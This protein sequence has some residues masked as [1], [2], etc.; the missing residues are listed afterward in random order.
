MSH[1]D[2]SELKALEVPSSP[3]RNLARSKTLPRHVLNPLARAQELDGL[4]VDRTKLPKLR[5][6]M[7]AFVLGGCCWLMIYPCAHEPP[8]QLILTSN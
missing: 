1:P 5:R 3:T 2:F 7:L 8:A 4:P 6:W